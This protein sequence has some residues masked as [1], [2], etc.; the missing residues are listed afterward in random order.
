MAKHLED[1]DLNDYLKTHICY[2]PWDTISIE[3]NGNVIQCCYSWLPKVIGNLFETPD[4]ND[5]ID[6][7]IAREVQDSILDG[8]YRFCNKDLC[9]EIYSKRLP[10]RPEELNV[11]RKPYKIRF[12]NDLSCN[13]WCPSCRTSRIQHN[14]GDEYV[15]S[16][17]LNDR[18]VKYVLERMEEGPVKIWVTGSGDAIGSKIFRD[19]LFNL[20]GRNYPDLE[21]YLMTNGVLFTPKIWQNLSRIWNNIRLIDISVDAGSFEIYQKVRPPG[22]WEQ[23]LSNARFLGEMAKTHRQIDINYGFVVQQA[24]Y[25]DMVNFVNVFFQFERF[26]LLN[27]TL[28]NDWH[29]WHDFTPHAVWKP[30]HPEYQQF[31][32]MVNRDELKHEK[33]FMGSL[34]RFLT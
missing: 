11:T 2:K 6:S 13:L 21:I 20:D 23:L 8:S 14:E 27:F 19:M 28:I 9:S 15:K 29:T 4:L 31:I 3:P 30:S 34:T 7:E 24:N 33:V 10:K 18:I 22:Q 12:S 5:I 26:N 16:K 32:D 1:N 17:L 25:L